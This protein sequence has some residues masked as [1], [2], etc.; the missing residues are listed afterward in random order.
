MILPSRDRPQVP[1][2]YG[3]P[4]TDDGVLDWSVVEERLRSSTEYWMATT[5][6]DGRPHV[7][8]RWGV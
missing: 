2:S 5:R 7:V 4:D 8:P 3:V 6:A 1:D